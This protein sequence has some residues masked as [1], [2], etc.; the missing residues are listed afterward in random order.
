MN[1]SIM[2][3][4]AQ[5]IRFAVIGL[6]WLILAICFQPLVLADGGLPLLGENAAINIEEERRLGYGF[7][8]QLLASG[9][10]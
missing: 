1:V 5:G 7:Y 4:T 8:R 3:R 10:I 9:V 6:Q 2:N